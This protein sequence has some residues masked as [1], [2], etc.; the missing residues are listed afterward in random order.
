LTLRRELSDGDVRRIVQESIKLINRT[1][2]ETRLPISPNLASTRHRLSKGELKAKYINKGKNRAYAMDFGNFQPPN[3]IYLD[4]RLPS[5]DHPMNLPDFADTMIAYS[6]IH[7]VIHADDH[8]GGDKLL[9][10]TRKHILEAHVDKLE[11]SMEILMNDG[12]VPCIDGYA[13]LASLWAVQYV[14][15]VTHYRSYVVLRHMRYPKLDQIWSRLRNDYFP[16]NLL[17]NIEVTKGTEYVFSLFTEKL[18]KYC[19]IEALKEYNVLKE[20]VTAS[21]M[22]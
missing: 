16:P 1:Q 20:K 21:Y 7:E 6:G 18:G 3:V 17:T 5:C 11:K 13:D 22:V 12:G 8:T 9:L 14:D 2:K 19:L 4:K 15:M 10:A